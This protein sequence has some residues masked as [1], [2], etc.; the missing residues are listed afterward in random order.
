MFLNTIII[1]IALGQRRAPRLLEHSACD[2]RLDRSI[3]SP[4]TPQ[5][6]ALLD[7]EGAVSLRTPKRH[8]LV[9]HAIPPAGS[10]TC[11]KTRANPG[12]VRPGGLR[13]VVRA[14]QG[15]S[16]SHTKTA[17]GSGS[18]DGSRRRLPALR[19]ASCPAK[20][21]RTRRGKL[22]TRG[23]HEEGKMQAVVSNANR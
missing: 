4:C 3:A 17:Q 15:R 19:G 11:F 1:Y 7:A 23:T 6:A 16:L 22:R 20:R 8:S 9:Q 14:R 21:R 13:N 5:T 12:G 2:H 10:R 18:N